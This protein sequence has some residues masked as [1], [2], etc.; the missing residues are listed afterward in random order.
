VTVLQDAALLGFVALTIAAVLHLRRRRSQ[1]AAFLVAAFGVM[2]AVLVSSR[3]GLAG[4]DRVGPV[5][6]RVTVVLLAAFPW[7]LAAFAWSFER[8]TPRWLQAA[9]VVALG[10]G[11]WGA[12]LA[13]FPDPQDR[14]LLEEL[15]VLVF[16]GVW[17]SLL[18]AA[19]VRLWTAGGRQRLVRARMRL[20]AGG[21][22]AMTVALFVSVGGSGTDDEVVRGLA[23]LLVVLSAALFVAGFAPPLPLRVW[24]RRRA[25]EQFQR[26]QLAL[27]AASTP[28]EVGQAVVPTLAELLGGAVVL[29]GPYREVLASAQLEPE[30]AAALARRLSTGG[31]FDD[32]TLVVPVDSSWLLIRSNPYTPVFGQDEQ[33]L[34]T[35]FSLQMRMALERAELFATNLAAQEAAERARDELEAMLYGLSHDLRS[36]AVAIAGF[37]ALLD[38]VDDE[39]VRREMVGRIQASTAY[40]NDLVDAL[41]ELSRIGRAQDEVAPVH[42]GEVARAVA[43]RVEVTHPSVTV[44]IADPLPVVLLNPGRAEQLVDNLVGNAVKHGGRDDLTVA[45]SARRPTRGHGEGV[46]LVVADDGRGVRAEERERIFGLFARGA[47]AA[48]KGSGLGLGMVQRIAESNGGHVR[49]D[50]DGPGATFVVWLPPAMVVDR[51][52]VDRNDADRP[53]TSV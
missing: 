32:D 44:A 42:L 39:E 24:W 27:I 38:E 5:A 53:A 29:V 37:A 16:I 21:M 4:L 12:T 36:P 51:N 33:Q 7:L 2:A 22:L 50:P 25:N 52:V 49:L 43:H 34:V 13:P 11:L 20:M 3:L 35:G 48:G 26:M 41:L 17:G 23:Q 1:P 9:G 6:S 28:A 45:I 18:I 15:Y 10:L 31:T 30:R 8:R 46:E 19:G 47:D 14:S 40:L